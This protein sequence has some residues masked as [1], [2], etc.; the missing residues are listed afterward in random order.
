[1]R[2]LENRNLSLSSSQEMTGA[3]LTKESQATE[4]K[5]VDKD[6]RQEAKVNACF[7]QIIIRK[8]WLFRV[9]YFTSTVNS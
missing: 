5:T 1:M 3:E 9:E 8:L 4:A 6:E 7:T 2:I